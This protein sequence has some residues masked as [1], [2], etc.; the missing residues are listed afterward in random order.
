[1]I[2]YKQ[3]IIPTGGGFIPY[4]LRYS[5]KGRFLNKERATGKS[6][7]TLAEASRAAKSRVIQL[8]LS[9]AWAGGKL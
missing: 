1:M 8:R 4:I 9:M 6:C 7:K 2:K 3:E 5:K